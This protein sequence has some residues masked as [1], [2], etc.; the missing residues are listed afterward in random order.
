MLIAQANLALV[1]LRGI[2]WAAAVADKAAGALLELS[3]EGGLV[4]VGNVATVRTDVSSA[5]VVLV[6][7]C[8]FGWRSA[9]AGGDCVP[10]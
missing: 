4:A 7:R 2:G 10:A 1:Y 8:L 6:G 3:A 5:P 9:T